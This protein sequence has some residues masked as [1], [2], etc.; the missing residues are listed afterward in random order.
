MCSSDLIIG[1][2]LGKKGADV[3]WN[4]AGRM[5][6]AWVFTL[7]SA[8]IVG[9]GAYALANAIGGT[10]G[11][12]V[13]TILLIGVGAAIYLR[14]RKTTVNPDNVNT[15]WTGTVAPPTTTEPAAAPAAA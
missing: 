9:A 5:A 2:G 8:G 12:V 1:T 7:P 11:V 10:A 15:E 3:R 6:T 14:S 4:V 13:D